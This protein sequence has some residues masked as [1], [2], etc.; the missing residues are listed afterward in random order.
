MPPS[1]LP[2]SCLTASD[3]PELECHTPY[4]HVFTL[5]LNISA[6]A[7][8][9]F[10]SLSTTTCHKLTSHLRR[11]SLDDRLVAMTSALMTWH[12]EAVHTVTQRMSGPFC[13][14]ILCNPELGNHLIH[15]MP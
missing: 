6:M 10:T 8:F 14:M 7:M 4:E 15:L 3:I 9:D 1:G 5:T 12:M 13:L 2:T 11:S